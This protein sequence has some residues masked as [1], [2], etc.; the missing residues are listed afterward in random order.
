MVDA[1]PLRQLIKKAVDEKN[2]G[3]HLGASKVLFRF[4]RS[5]LA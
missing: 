3:L 1:Q 2:K 4:L 5:S